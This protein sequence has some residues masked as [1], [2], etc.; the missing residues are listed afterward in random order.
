MGEAADYYLVEGAKVHCPKEAAIGDWSIA[1]SLL[2][3]DLGTRFTAL[4][5]DLAQIV[6]EIACELENMD[7]LK[8]ALS[9]GGNISSLRVQK[10]LSAQVTA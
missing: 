4:R 9:K 10:R 6:L 3:L 1:E 5:K 7:L 2:A 8:K